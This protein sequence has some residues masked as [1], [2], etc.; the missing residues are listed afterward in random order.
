MT[1]LL[2]DDKNN[3]VASWRMS[4]SQMSWHS[5]DFQM[6]QQDGVIRLKKAFGRMKDTSTWKHQVLEN[7]LRKK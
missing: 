7:L 3:P 5:K 4:T 2:R 6:A 1:E